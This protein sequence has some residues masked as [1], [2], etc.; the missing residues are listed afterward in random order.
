MRI[1]GSILFHHA[2]DQ[3]P[4][5]RLLCGVW[6]GDRR[7]GKRNVHD[8]GNFKERSH[9]RIVAVCTSDLNGYYRCLACYAHCRI[10][11]CCYCPVLYQKEN[12]TFEIVAVGRKNLMSLLFLQIT[13]IC[14]A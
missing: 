1:S 8:R 11:H 7:Y 5:G 4:S 3:S 10:D 6:K 12:I 9:Q 13:N 2:Q 14:T